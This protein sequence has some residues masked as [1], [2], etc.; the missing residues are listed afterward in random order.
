MSK[1]PY[2]IYP[3]R[4]WEVHDPNTARLLAVFYDEDA[5]ADYLKFL[6][7]EDEDD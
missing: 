3:E 7:R 6:S 2:E 4:V 1:V 5:A